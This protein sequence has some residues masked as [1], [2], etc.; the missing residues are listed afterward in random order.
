MADLGGGEDRLTEF[1]A[2]SFAQSLTAVFE[3]QL[4]QIVLRNHVVFDAPPGIKGIL[5]QNNFA[6][7]VGIRESGAEVIVS[8][9]PLLCVS[10]QFSQA[11]SIRR[12]KSA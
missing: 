7:D 9:V 10:G 6:R 4:V 5:D 2:R 8:L 3:Q 11:V 12:W 1:R